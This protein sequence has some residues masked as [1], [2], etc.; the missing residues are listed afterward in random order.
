MG[1]F[2]NR[3]IDDGKA[4]DNTRHLAVH[5]R[6]G[7]PFLAPPADIRRVILCSGQ[8]YYMLSRWGASA[9][10]GACVD[11]LK[12]WFKK[13]C[14]TPHTVAPLVTMLGSVMGWTP[15]FAGKQEL[16]M[17]VAVLRWTQVHW[18]C[19]V[20]RSVVLLVALHAV[21]QQHM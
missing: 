14:S 18:C 1:H 16:Y 9:G 2:F 10:G 5:P 13:D 17:L 21:T 8:I 15:S 4:S 6:T 3:V 20:C 19:C 11:V 12:G 7:Q